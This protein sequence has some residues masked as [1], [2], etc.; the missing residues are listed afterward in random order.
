MEWSSLKGR[1]PRWF[2]VRKTT[3]FTKMPPVTAA[4]HVISLTVLLSFLLCL[5]FCYCSFLSL[6]SLLWLFL[7]PSITKFFFIVELFFFKGSFL[8][9]L[10]LFM[11]FSLAPFTLKA[12][13][14]VFFLHL[15]PYISF[16]GLCHLGISLG[17]SLLS[18]LFHGVVH[19]RH[20]LWQGDCN[21]KQVVNR[22][23]IP[24]GLSTLLFHRWS[25]VPSRGGVR[26]DSP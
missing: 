19:M 21:R 5:A 26:G 23:K 12:S 6:F 4:G 24:Q 16:C 14:Q 13:F 17:S 9:W 1:G 11:A 2:T 7:W 18:V 8:P 10:L 22:L 3:C 25:E 15:L 20:R